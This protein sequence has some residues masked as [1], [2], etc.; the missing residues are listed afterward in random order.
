[1][2]PKQKHNHFLQGIIMLSTKNKIL[3]ISKQIS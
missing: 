3:T 1:M 2:P